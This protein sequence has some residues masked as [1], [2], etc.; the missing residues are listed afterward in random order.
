MRE[1]DVL[2]A[3]GKA[4]GPATRT[5]PPRPW[6][7]NGEAM[8]SS[9]FLME[10]VLR[11]GCEGYGGFNP[12]GVV[13]LFHLN[14]GCASRPRIG[15]PLESLRDRGTGRRTFIGRSS[16]FPAASP[17]ATWRADRMRSVEEPGRLSL[18]H[19]SV[20]GSVSPSESKT[21]RSLRFERWGGL[22]VDDRV[23]L[24]WPTAIAALTRG[25]PAEESRPGSSHWL[26]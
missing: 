7:L 2:I 19:V 18:S 1:G 15:Y 14:P 12:S 24:N 23:R 22:G 5:S 21:K 4:L 9:P 20:S 6:I 25:Y 13:F 17:L 3:M 16:R 11:Q 26:D 8:S 10:S